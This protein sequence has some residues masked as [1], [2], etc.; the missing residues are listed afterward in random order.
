[1][2]TI[3]ETI[4]SHLA[5]MD[6]DGSGDVRRQCPDCGGLF[7]R[8]VRMCPHCGGDSNRTAFENL[9]AGLIVMPGEVETTIIWEVE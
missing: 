5:K 9:M 3:N 7:E 2:T 6:A 4:S 8:K 1:M